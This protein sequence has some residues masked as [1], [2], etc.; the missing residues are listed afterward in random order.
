MP[1]D[2]ELPTGPRFPG[3]DNTVF[4]VPG[5]NKRFTGREADLRELRT[6]LRSSPKVVLSGTGPV[7]LRGMGGIG[8]SQLALEY[9]HRYRAAYDMV[10]WIDADQVPFIES[11][12]GDLA[13]YLGVPSSESNRGNARL[14]LQAL[15]R[16]DL[17]WLLIM[18]NADEVEGVPPYVPD[19][20]GHVVIT[21]RNLQWVERAT[22]IPVDVFKRAESIQHLTERVPTMRVDQADRI[23]ALLGDLPIAVTAAAAWLADTGHSVDSYLT[24]IAVRSGRGDGTEQQRLGGGHLGAVAQPPADPEP[25][26]LPGAATVLGVRP[27][28]LRRPGLQRRVRRGAGAVPPAGEGTAGPPATGAAGQPARPGPRRPAGREP[29]RRRAGRGGLVLM[30]RLLQHAVRSRMTEEELDEARRRRRPARRGGRP[31]RLAPVPG[32]LAA[33]GGVEGTAEPPGGGAGADDRPGPLPPVA[34]RPGDRPAAR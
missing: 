25:G 3:R 23:A 10:W 17:R 31:R 6:L 16:T 34:R 27:G 2:L 19:G 30:H 7:A 11:A 15:R 26:G 32:H 28:D 22:T 13:P 24:E 8:K 4:E 20:K 18:D 5:R 33:P 12:I 14:V 29:V 9:A 21:S 1:A